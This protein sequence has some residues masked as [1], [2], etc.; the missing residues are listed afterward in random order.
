MRF[1]PAYFADGVFTII[2]HEPAVLAL[3]RRYFFV[4]HPVELADAVEFVAATE[5]RFDAI[6]VDI[7][8]GAGFNGPPAAFWVRCGAIPRPPGG[9]AIN[10]ADVRAQ[11]IYST[12][13]RRAGRPTRRSF[14]PAPAGFKSNVGHPCSAQPPLD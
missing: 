9:I 13:A 6:F 11:A 10:W 4:D 14:F 1:L 3:A 12:P 8:G 5:V 7:Y 2:E